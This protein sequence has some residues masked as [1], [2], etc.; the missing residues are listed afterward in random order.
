MRSRRPKLYGF[1]ALLLC[2]VATA[3]IAQ[4]ARTYT[5]DALGRLI[6]QE[7]TGTPN[8]G[9]VHSICYDAAG[10]RT[11]YRTSEDGSSAGCDPGI[12]GAAPTPTPSPSP[13]P[14]PT[15]TP[16]GNN[17]PITVNDSSSGDC[18]SLRIVNLTANDSDPESNYPLTLTAISQNSGQ[19]TA[20]LGSAS[21]V[22]V[23]FG[24]QFDSSSF[25]YTVEDSLGA[26]ATGQLSVSTS[27]C[28]TE[29]Y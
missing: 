3:A 2:G 13:T 8:N 25:T 23:E 7:S 20:M 16:T 10:N 18:Y 6:E 1:T 5:Y 29:Q 17:P 4:D 11:Q 22:T 28:G 27:G 12:P 26:S 21:S 19:A 24:P 14:T 15:P 9:E